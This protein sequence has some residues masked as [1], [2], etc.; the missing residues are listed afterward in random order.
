[1]VAS[2]RDLRLQGSEYRM[3]FLLFLRLIIDMRQADV[4]AENYLK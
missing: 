4:E 2:N 1:M 3:L